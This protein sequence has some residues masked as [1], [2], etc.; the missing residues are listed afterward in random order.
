[1]PLAS[2]DILVVWL[3]DITSAEENA[4]A[5][6]LVKPDQHPE[7]WFPDPLVLFTTYDHTPRDVGDPSIIEIAL[8][9]CQQT[10]TEPAPKNFLKFDDLAHFET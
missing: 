2:V 3:V 1:L 7:F 4:F 8:T 5:I 6:S 10:S 9:P